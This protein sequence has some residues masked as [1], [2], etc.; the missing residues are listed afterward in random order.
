MIGPYWMV[1]INV[2]ASIALL[3]GIVFYIRI[4]PKKKV[5]FL[6]LLILISLLPLI[7]ILR[8]GSYESGDLSTHAMLSISFFE[9]LIEKDFVPIWGGE[10]NATYGYPAFHFIYPLPYY[11]ISAIHFLGFSF[12]ASVKIL[13]AF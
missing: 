10:M 6:V 13:L 3:L 5:N 2:I 9:S 7:S 12:I 4:F 1:F 11:I 8:S